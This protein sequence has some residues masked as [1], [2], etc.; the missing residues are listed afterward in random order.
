LERLLATAA[1]RPG[2]VDATALRA[3]GVPALWGT[4]PRPPDGEPSSA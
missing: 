1:L 3:G 4:G 2:S